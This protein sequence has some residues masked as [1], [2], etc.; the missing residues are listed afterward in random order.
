[1]QALKESAWQRSVRDQK[2][3]VHVEVI[4]ARRGGT[5]NSVSAFRRIPHRPPC[6]HEVG[7]RH[8]GILA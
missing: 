1:M 6:R 2:V 5:R 4:F 7:Q 3:A 8:L